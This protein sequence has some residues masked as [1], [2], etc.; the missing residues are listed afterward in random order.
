MIEELWYYFK[1]YDVTVDV[2]GINEK[3]KI[4][5]QKALYRKLNRINKF[6]R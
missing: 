4:K 3:D 2:D 6:S 5:L 1:S